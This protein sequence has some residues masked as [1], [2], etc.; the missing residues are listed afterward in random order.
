MV[1]SLRHVLRRASQPLVVAALLQAGLLG[2][3]GQLHAAPDRSEVPP[4]F[5]SITDIDPSVIVEARYFEEH[6]FVGERIRGYNA[7]K[8]LLT[9]AAT[10]A[11]AEVQ[12]DLAPYQLALKVYD[13]YRPQRAVDHFVEWAKDLSDTKMEAEFYPNV[14]K[15]DLIRDGYIAEKSGH[16]R[17]STLDVT[18]VALPPAGQD[19]YQN[20]DP[21]QACRLPAGERFA[22]NGLDM[23]TGFD[24]FDPLSHTANP[25][26]GLEQRKN[27]LL[28]KTLMD[29]HGF[30]NLPE[31]WWHFTLRDEPYPDTY[32]DFEIH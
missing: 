12:K 27:R 6:N 17:G 29:R 28:L 8:C 19:R 32:F 22:D 16:S 4:S 3:A 20:G 30:T 2:S 31:E 26:V 5:V 7:P 10:Q 23:G 15:A 25:Q 14:E 24:C 18:L 13:C 11:V 1:R 21:L 9:E